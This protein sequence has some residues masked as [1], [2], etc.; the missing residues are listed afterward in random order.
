MLESLLIGPRQSRRMVG[1]SA[2]YSR[3]F[4]PIKKEPR[5]GFLIRHIG[6]IPRV[7]FLNLSLTEI[8]RSFRIPGGPTKSR[9]FHHTEHTLAARCR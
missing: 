1:T 2:N 8:I 9:S 5:L 7:I 6:L 4:F 3:E